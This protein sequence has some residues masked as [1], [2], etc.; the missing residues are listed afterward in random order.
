MQIHESCRVSFGTVLA[1]LFGGG[2]PYASLSEPQVL[3]CVLNGQHPATLP[4][5]VDKAVRH[6]LDACWQADPTARPSVDV[7][8]DLV[9]AIPI[10]G[11]I[12][13]PQVH[14]VA[15]NAVLPNRPA[16]KH[17]IGTRRC[18]RPGPSHATARH[19]TAP[20]LVRP[21]I[22]QHEHGCGSTVAH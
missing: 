14:A 12:A 8:V 1:E 20:A 6:I 7:L 13:P 3:M 4:A 19:N 11:A 22:Q 15:C 16:A 9:A 2:V 17:D 21:R 10:R 18:W 5:H